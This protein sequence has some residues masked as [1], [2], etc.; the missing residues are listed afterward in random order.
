M[1]VKPRI[2]ESLQE[3]ATERLDK[4]IARAYI[5][6]LVGLF[7]GAVHLKPEKVEYGG[8]SFIIDSAEKLQGIIDFVCLLYYVGMIGVVI[9]YGLQ[10]V[11]SN[12]ALMRRVVYAALGKK[13]TIVGL[14]KRGHAVLRGSAR[15]MYSLA[16]ICLALITLFPVIHIVF[17]QQPVLLAGFD[18]IFQTVSV[19]DGRIDPLAPATLLVTLFLMSAW[20]LIIYRLFLRILGPHIELLFA[21]MVSAA[22]F[23]YLDSAVRTHEPYTASLSRAIG[24]QVMI[25]VICYSPQIIASPFMGWLSV[26][27][28]WYRWRIKRREK[29]T[30]QKNSNNPWGGKR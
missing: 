30:A 24:L 27:M 22:T 11:N 20:T 12:R 21:N 2:N 25:L 7:V 3:K 18:A 8:L 16:L 10:N 19:R 23:A 6:W 4:Q 13:R 28:A 1:A 14:D 29:K 15:F 5:I 26:R 17:F 9:L